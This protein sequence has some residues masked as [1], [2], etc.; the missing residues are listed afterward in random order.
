MSTPS[1]APQAASSLRPSRV[2]HRFVV[3]RVL[4]LAGKPPLVAT[5]WDGRKIKIG[6]AHV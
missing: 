4:S 2:W 5:L 6:R 3:E 1:V